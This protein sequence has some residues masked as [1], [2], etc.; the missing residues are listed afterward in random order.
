TAPP[1]AA[2][3]VTVTVS[4]PGGAASA[5]SSQFTYQALPTVSAV[6]PTFGPTA[7]GTPVTIIG[8]G[9]VPG[10][11]VRF[12]ASAATNVVVASA[13]A[14][15]ASSPAGASGAVNVTVTTPAGTSAA[16]PA[17][18]FTY[19]ATPTV[20]A[21]NPVAGP[22]TGGT[23]VTIIGTGFVPGAT[24]RFGASAATNVVVAS[25]TAITASSP[26]GTAGTTAHVT[27]TT[28]AGTSA[29]VPADQFT[30]E[31]APAV[32]ALSPTVGPSTGGTSVTITGTGFLSGATVRFGASAATNV[33]VAGPTTITATAPAGVSGAVNVT[34]TTP[35]GTSPIVSADQFTYGATPTVTSLN[36]AAGPTAAGTPVTITGSGFVTGA[37]VRFGSTAATSVVVAG[38]TTI[39]ATAPA[40]TAGTTVNV[41]VATPSGTSPVVSADQFTYDALPSVT[42][43]SP[44]FGPAAGGTSVTVTGTGFLSGATVRFGPTAATNVVVASP[45]TIT[46]TAPAGTAGAVNVTVITPGGTSATGT[47]NQFTYDATPTVTGLSPASSLTTGGTSVTITGTGFVTGATV[48][49]GSSP[50]TA[51]VVAGPTTITVTAP[52]RAVGAV[53]VTVTTPGGTSATGA[54]SQFS[55]VTY[56]LAPLSVT[57]TQAG[58][59]PDLT[60]DWTPSTGGTPATGAIVQLYQLVSGAY[61]YRQGISCGASCTSTVFRE[62]AVGGTYAALVWPTITLGPGS[63]AASGPATLTTTCGAGACVTLNANQAI[64]PANHAAS[65][66]LSSVFDIGTLVADL[67]G[68]N[69]TMFRSAP[70]PIAL[71]LY[72]WASWNEAVAA[73]AQTTL[74]LSDEYSAA[75]GGSPPTPWSNWTAYNTEIKALVSTLAASGEPINYW[76]VYNEPGGNDSYYSAAGY[77]TETPALLLQQFLYT[78]QDI[79][80]EVPNAAIIG[81]SLEH[82]SDYPDQYGTADHAFDM[83]TFLNFA[84]AN[85]LSLAAISWHEI[86]DNL[87][88][89]PEENSLAPAMIE[90]H[91]SEARRLIAALPALGHPKVFVNEYGMPEVQTIPGWDV[92]YL[93]ALTEAQVDS[94]DRA[95]WGTCAN[96][97]LDGLL[98]LAG[99]STPTYYER[100]VYAATS[101]NMIATTSSTDTVNAVAS[102]NSSSGVLT[103]L[104]G[105]GVGCSQDATCATNWPGATDAAPTSVTVTITVPWT[106]GLAALALTD[107]E[108]QTDVAETA[109][110][111][112]NSTATVVP[113]GSGG[114][115]VSFSIPSFADGD[116]YGLSLTHTTS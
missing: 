2:G 37:T 77:A 52:A 87:G 30:Y 44:T 74:V 10:A 96:P 46:A 99:L 93:A 41:T 116:A 88:T 33:V 6:S 1:G 83:V 31:A 89:A 60:V 53:Y 102:Y 28:P 90:D 48:L 43:V 34:V 103:A 105:R 32:T 12:G 55:Y 111:P 45:T 72:D 63:P 71:G 86:D 20:G 115:T 42:A 107:F 19:G 9:F 92:A 5:G 62:L 68:L 47:A 84:A 75:Y 59:A 110:T 16:V 81:P 51:V 22:T 24:V 14:I 18:Q 35:G 21:I 13:T 15:T 8:T 98:T 65:G 104:I 76:E 94:A 97:S 113:N 67:V 114:G 109:P 95:C 17:D 91:V 101:G 106:S 100:L 4:P 7:G 58:P 3:A 29:V 85:N 112:A 38:P 69:T 82:W 39:T 66:I 78:Y 23:P 61:V 54:A 36:P 73:G 57:A 26:A 80:A 79:K 11:T 64:G 49:F 27:V 70:P 56:P 108:G 40:G 50:G 25:A